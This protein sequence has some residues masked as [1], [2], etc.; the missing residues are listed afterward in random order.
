MMD[1]RNKMLVIGAGPVGLG[2][3]KALGE[4]D[5]PYVQV[6][7]T[8]HVG[9]NWA[10]GVYETAHIISSRDTT[11]YSDWPMPRSYPDFPS[12]AQMKAYYEAYT[13]EFGLAEHIRFETKVTAVNPRADELWDV[14]FE[15]GTTQTFKGVFVCNG[16]HWSKIFP[17][18]AEDFAGELLHSKDY[19]RPDQLK[20]KRVLTIGGGNSGC[21]VAS[22]AARV[23]ACS[24]WSLR[25]GY[26]FM[27][28]TLFGT[29][30]IELVKPWMPMR[31]QR[32]MLK[33]LIRITVGR[34]EDYG[35]PTPDHEIFETHPTVSTEVFHYLKHGRIAPRPDVAKVD[36]H[37]VT[38]KDGTSADYDVIVCA[39]GF[40]VAFPFLP[41]GMVPV[42]GKVAKLIGGFVT[43]TDKHLY[44]VGW[45]QPR[46]GL[47]PLVRPASVLL[48]KMAKIQDD[49]EP[50]IGAVLQKLGAPVPDTHLMDPHESMRR[51]A[52]ATRALPLVRRVGMRM[53]RK[54]EAP[55]RA[56]VAGK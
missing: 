5:V 48:A 21:D 35:L 13:A 7:A 30:T 51:L 41:E 50:P 55:M 49:F 14:T 1:T 27:P 33:T 31:L 45:S 6:E 20:G 25:R 11:Q 56:A 42:E 54:W 47:G 15:D 39:T 17:D 34:Y 46:Y 18:W 32:R 3:A 26:W 53:G 44:I 12:A 43:P 24:D 8:D 36:G 2:M 38:F 37:T 4:E 28:K 40:H 52:R 22:E 10:H 19:K 29:P 23:G 9:G 16:H